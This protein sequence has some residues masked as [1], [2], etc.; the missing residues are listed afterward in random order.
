M[1]NSIALRLREYSGSA[2]LNQEVP[3]KAGLG[4]GVTV[5]GRKVPFQDLL[6]DGL[7][8]SDAGSEHMSRA[9]PES[10]DWK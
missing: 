5:D 10:I 2:R 9:I 4:G 1:A 6:S 8:L 3:A 7:H